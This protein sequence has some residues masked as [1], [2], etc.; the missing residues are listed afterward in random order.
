MAQ[1]VLAYVNAERA[2]AGLGPVTWN[3]TLAN[4]ASIRASEI[5]VTWAHT[6]PDGSKW[7][8]AGS[9]TQMAENLAYG[10]TTAAQVVA[11]WMASPSHQANLMNGNY[12]QMGVSCYYCN[13]TYYWAQLFAY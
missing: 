8:T 2:A 12:S 11:E 4:D 7:W 10:Q 13:G 1:E 9:M 6:R 3:G 5:V